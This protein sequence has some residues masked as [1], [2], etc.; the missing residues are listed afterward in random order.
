MVSPRFV[1]K[2][3]S[4][5]PALRLAVLIDA[6]N[7]QAAVRLRWRAPRDPDDGFPSWGP[8]RCIEH[9]RKGLA[10]STWRRGIESCCCGRLG[11]VE[12]TRNRLIEGADP[13]RSRRGCGGP[14]AF[15]FQPVMVR[16]S[17]WHEAP[18]FCSSISM[19]SCTRPVPLRRSGFRVPTSLRRCGRPRAA[20]S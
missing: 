18:R 5:E 11:S 1:A 19:A 2:I 7:A 13:S 16:I 12:S 3:E 14:G 9:D 15:A 20:A 4:E 10:P 8:D 6:D 17:I